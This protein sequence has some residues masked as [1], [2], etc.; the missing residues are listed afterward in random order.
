MN[1]VKGFVSPRFLYHSAVC[2]IGG[3]V[4]TRRASRISKC[5]RNSVARTVGANAAR[6]NGSAARPSSSTSVAACNGNSSDSQSLA[7]FVR[8]AFMAPTF[9]ASRAP[10]QAARDRSAGLLQSKRNPASEMGTHQT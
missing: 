9:A 5:P 1:G 3:S 4:N 6:S 2:A 7:A 8:V 10:R